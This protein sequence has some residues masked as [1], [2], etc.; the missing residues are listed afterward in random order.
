LDANNPRIQSNLAVY[1]VLHGEA[2]DATRWMNEHQM[3][4]AQ[5]LRVFEV[6]QRIAVQQ[7]QPL[8]APVQETVMSPVATHPSACV[9][10]LIFEHKLA[11]PTS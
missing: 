4:Q 3:N 9:G 11:L 10:C 1:L 8:P 6:A 7:N 2:T 5:R